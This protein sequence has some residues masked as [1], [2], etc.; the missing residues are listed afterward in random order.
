MLLETLERQASACLQTRFGRE[1]TC[2]VAAP[3]RVN[4]I[5]EHV[6]YNAGLVL[7]MAIDR[8]VLMAAGL[9]RG[10]AVIR[11]HSAHFDQQADLQPGG[12]D[13]QRLPAWARYCGAVLR[14]LQA[15]GLD[16]PAFEAAIE[17]DLPVASGLSSSAAVT[18]CFATL[19]EHL[20]GHTLD[21]VDKARVCQQ[22]EHDAVGVPCGIMDPATVVLARAG[23]ALAIDCR[24]SSFQD[25]ALWNGGLVLLVMHSGV[26]RTL[27][28]GP[29][30]RRRAT[31]ESA[32]AALGVRTLRELCP[33]DLDGVAQRLDGEAFRR[34]RHVV[35]EI[36][37]TRLA[38]QALPRRDWPAFG[39]LLDASHASLRD[40]FEVSCPELDLLTELLSAAVPDGAVLGRRL[41]GAGCGGC[42]I[43]LVLEEHAERVARDVIDTYRRRTGLQA[44]AWPA[45]AAQGARVVRDGPAL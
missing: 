21:P 36:E 30:A 44:A 32:A 42:V 43:A 12:R 22:A 31:C 37:R 17:A 33:A 15:R 8:G 19:C 10:A 11:L 23:C 25:V 9:A 1:P 14:G 20:G 38:L 40:D 24:S 27:A 41:T 2:V 5:G 29:Y 35:S 13:L 6:D 45:Q 34:V 39:R 26:R 4:L 16:V 28:E 7:P 3:G 18:V